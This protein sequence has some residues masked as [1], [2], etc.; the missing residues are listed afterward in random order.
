MTRQLVLDML[1]VTAP[2][3]ANYLPGQ[4]AEALAALK[5]LTP[6]H[7]I[8]LYGAAGCGRTHLARATTQ[9][10]GC[11]LMGPADTAALEAL[12]H[13]EG[14]TP[15]PARIAVDDVHR[16]DE[17]GQ[18][19]LFALYNRW[20]ESAATAG[21]F[22]LVVAGDRAPLNMPLREDL[23]TRLGWDLAFRLEPLSDDDKRA[24]LTAQAADR[25]LQLSPEVLQWM[26]THY[27]RD[28]RRLSALLIAVDR[29]SLAT[30]RRITVPL[31]RA[32]LADPDSPL[33]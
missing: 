20:R 24:A 25:G 28:I 6:G 16:M 30:G 29:H 2:T 9:S 19:A 23:R 32:M 13:A 10:N 3:L 15:L 7:A 8:Y 26:L 1:P 27:E 22:A 5:S 31:L 17:A 33:T 21:A 4:N 14:G 11:Y 18:A 12:A